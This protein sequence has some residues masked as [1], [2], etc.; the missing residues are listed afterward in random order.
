VANTKELGE[1]EEGAGVKVVAK[2]KMM[3]MYLKE[4]GKM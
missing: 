3:K 1:V 2:M 4:E